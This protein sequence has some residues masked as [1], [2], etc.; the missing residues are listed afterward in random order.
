L[1]RA[2]FLRSM[3]E[4]IAGSLLVPSLG[5]CRRAEEERPGETGPTVDPVAVSAVPRCVGRSVGSTS[6]FG[7]DCWPQGQPHSTS[8]SENVCKTPRRKIRPGRGRAMRPRGQRLP[9]PVAVGAVP[10][11]RPRGAL[12][13]PTCPN[14]LE[15]SALCARS[16][17]P[18]SCCRPSASIRR[19][20]APRCA[21]LLHKLG[22]SPACAVGRWGKAGHQRCLRGDDRRPR[23]APRGLA[24][25]RVVSRRWGLRSR[26]RGSLGL[27]AAC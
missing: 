27:D 4:V 13:P 1:E 22:P 23:P 14:G 24:H 3:T 10:V 8:Y 12:V 16:P 15:G 21:R 19:T 6:R 18:A 17:S 9:A 25:P 11:G 2:C 20:S 5:K 26:L 7:R